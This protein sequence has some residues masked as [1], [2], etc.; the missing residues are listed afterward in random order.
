MR[1]IEMGQA[2]IEGRQKRGLGMKVTFDGKVTRLSYAWGDEKPIAEI[3]NCKSDG[4]TLTI[5]GRSQVSYSSVS[6][7]NRIRAVF[8]AISGGSW[9]NQ[10]YSS[11]Q[12]WG[13][14][15]I[16]DSTLRMEITASRPLTFQVRGDQI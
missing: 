10:R 1:L 12:R 6:H 9:T 11:F 13:F 7:C 16:W 4:Y 8:L 15:R 3:T 14:V 2:L 5:Y